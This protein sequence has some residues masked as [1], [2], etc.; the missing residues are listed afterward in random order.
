MRSMQPFAL[1]PGLPDTPGR[2][3]GFPRGRL[4]TEDAIVIS[5]N[6]FR[7]ILMLEESR[8]FM[9]EASSPGTFLVAPPFALAAHLLK[10]RVY[11]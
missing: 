7:A 11:C 1:P 3:A 4:A 8:S 6:L 9:C 10:S 5:G 2:Q